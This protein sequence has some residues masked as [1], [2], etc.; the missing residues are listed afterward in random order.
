MKE[1][2]KAKDRK[3]PDPATRNYGDEMY[4]KGY[5]TGY[6]RATHDARKCRFFKEKSVRRVSDNYCDYLDDEVA[7]HKK[8]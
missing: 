3:L 8:K 6:A 5:E 1:P 4:S 7:K 2:T